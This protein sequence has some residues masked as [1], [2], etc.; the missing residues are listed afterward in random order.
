MKDLTASQLDFYIEQYRP[1][2]NATPKHIHK[3]WS[4]MTVAEKNITV[5]YLRNHSTSFVRATVAGH[6]IGCHIREHGT[7][8]AEQMTSIW[9]SIV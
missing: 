5:F 9:E 4:Q 6:A 2:G 8:T 1:Q 3:H 7:I